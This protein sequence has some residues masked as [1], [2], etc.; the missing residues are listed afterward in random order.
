MPYASL[1]QLQTYLNLDPA[2]D[3]E[4]L[5]D[6]LNRATK[7]IDR[8]TDRTFT[9]SDD[10][11][12]YGPEHVEGQDLFLDSDL[13]SLSSLTNGDG[14]TLA[15]TTYW[16]LP[17]NRPPYSVI[18]LKSAYSW[19]FNTDGEVAVEGSW[20]YAADAP[21]DIVQACVRLAA[22]F[23]RQKDA[24]VFGT[25]AVPGLGLELPATLPAD[26]RELLAPYRRLWYWF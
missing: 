3:E 9:A 7:A 15:D 20:G 10:T 23:Y 1:S 22:F 8:F 2:R 26:V 13:L 25:T 21:D 12:Y 5:N 24:Q 6:L 14:T 16:L 18:R 4:L 17:R 19:S 11:R